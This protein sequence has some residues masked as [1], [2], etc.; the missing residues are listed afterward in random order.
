MRNKTFMVENRLTNIIFPKI[1]TYDIDVVSSFSNLLCFNDVAEF[2]PTRYWY[3]ELI[4]DYIDRNNFEY[5]HKQSVFRRSDLV[6]RVPAGCS[7]W[8]LD[9]CAG[10]TMP[11]TPSRATL[12]WRKTCGRILS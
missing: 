7:A 3:A 9:K 5:N 2:K 12:Q 6:E 8:K 4:S 1:V 10:G 11:C